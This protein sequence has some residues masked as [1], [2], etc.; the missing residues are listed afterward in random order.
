MDT[1]FID[2]EFCKMNKKYKEESKICATEIIQIGAV[3]LDENLNIVKKFDELV[4]PDYST[5]NKYV[6]ALTHITESDVAAALH[7]TE[8][9]DKFLEWVGDDKVDVYSWCLCDKYQF[10]NESKLKGYSDKRLDM[11]YENWFDFQLIFGNILEVSQKISLTNALNGVG[12]TF[13]GQKHSAADDAENT[14]RLFILT[15]DEEKFKKE[16]KPLLDLMIPT[17]EVTTELGSLFTPEILSKLSL[18]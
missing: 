4:K 13:K 15:K 14:A 16:A 17:P 9:M 12:I 8:A 7:F 6:S 5:I 3:R 1:I 10:E 2:L 18:D 11:L